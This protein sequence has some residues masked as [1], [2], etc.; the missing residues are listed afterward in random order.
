MCKYQAQVKIT[1]G[2]TVS[3]FISLP[4][5]ESLKEEVSTYS[6]RSQMPEQLLLSFLLKG[7]TALVRGRKNDVCVPMCGK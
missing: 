5:A 6:T 7:N 3:L 1:I 2:N 4:L